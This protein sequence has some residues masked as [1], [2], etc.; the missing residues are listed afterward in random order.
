MSDKK[1]FKLSDQ[2]VGQIRELLQL[3]MLHGINF[4][5]QCRAVRLEE[6]EALPG[7]LILGEEYVNGWN[8]MAE[9]MLAQAQAKADQMG[10]TMVEEAVESER[11]V[12][13]SRDPAT[14]KLVGKLEKA[15]N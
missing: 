10:S 11:E 6:S 3:S 15:S 13:I 8:K 14:G 2:V 7:T 5:D 12:V 1:V 4:V 9:D